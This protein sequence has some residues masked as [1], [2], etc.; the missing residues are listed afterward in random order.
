MGI[1]YSDAVKKPNI[2][3]EYTPEMMTELH[4]C[5]DDIWNFMDYIKIVHPDKGLITFEPYQFQK[6]VLRNLQNHRFNIILCSRQA[7]KCVH[8][9]TM[10]SVRNKKTGE[11]QEITIG[12]LFSKYKK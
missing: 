8:S 5:S 3:I 10:V 11:I 6:N 2:E 4:R 7:G 1:K 9:N 12:E